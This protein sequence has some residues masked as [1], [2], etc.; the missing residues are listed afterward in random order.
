LSVFSFRF[1]VTE[2]IDRL[3]GGSRGG[4]LLPDI[5]LKTENRKLETVDR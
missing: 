3:E 1:D 2:A 4:L 5:E